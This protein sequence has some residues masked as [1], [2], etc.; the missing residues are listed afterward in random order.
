MSMET[1]GYNNHM[2]PSM[3]VPN[4]LL[5]INQ[6]GVPQLTWNKHKHNYSRLLDQQ[7]GQPSRKT[8]F[9]EDEYKKMVLEMDKV[10]PMQDDKTVHPFDELLQLAVLADDGF[11]SNYPGHTPPLTS[12]WSKCRSSRVS[13]NS[14]L[15]WERYQDEKHEL[16]MSVIKKLEL[17]DKER[18]RYRQMHWK[19][20]IVNM[21]E[22]RFALDVIGGCMFPK[23]VET[24][25]KKKP[26]HKKYDQKLLCRHFAEGYCR[27]GATCDFQHDTLN[28]YPDSQKVFLGGLSHSITSHKLVWELKKKGYKV[29]NKPKIFRRFSPQV[30]LGS[31]EEAQKMLQR[32]TITIEGCTVDVRP[33]KA[34]T[35]KEM[36]RQLDKNRR[37]V[38]LGGLPSTI[39]VRILKTEI[40]K[41]G[42]KVTNRPLIKA[43]FIPKVTLATVNQAKQLIA[44]GVIELNGANVNVR[45][46]MLSKNRT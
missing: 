34:F 15:E 14:L 7:L 31:V 19:K 44:Q 35:Q 32:G 36:D 13:I 9:Y 8:S 22:S 6:R 33:Y 5:Q 4:K 24:M 26:A 10:E 29:I 40:Q 37:S 1:K 11:Q 39:T 43:G 20:S 30:C 23:V 21:I 41:L 16:F 17:Q 46:Y 25:S 18:F 38:F 28:S 2:V 45:P 3:E 42:M 12:V 27:R